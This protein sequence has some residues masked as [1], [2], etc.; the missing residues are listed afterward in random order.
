MKRGV[1]VWR[2]P[3]AGPPTQSF[4]PLAPRS[5]GRFTQKDVEAGRFGH[6]AFWLGGKDGLKW[7]ISGDAEHSLN[8]SRAQNPAP[9]MFRFPL[10][11]DSHLLGNAH[12]ASACVPISKLLGYPQF[13]R[14]RTPAGSGVGSEGL[15]RGQP[16]RG[17][18]QTG[19]E[20]NSGRENPAKAR[21]FR[22][23]LAADKWTVG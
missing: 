8:E 14:P 2:R 7:A 19:M 21:L 15:G 12:S 16:P 5:Q 6:S 18:L 20:G 17:A 10:C 22:E 1:A 4:I 11:Q 3:V 13:Q 23:P 9:S